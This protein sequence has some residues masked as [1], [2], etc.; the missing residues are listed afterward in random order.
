MEKIGSTFW[1][2]LFQIIA[3][4]S[5]KESPFDIAPV[6]ALGGGV[7]TFAKRSFDHIISVLQ[8]STKFVFTRDPYLRLLSGYVDKLFSPNPTF[9]K[10]IGTYAIRTHRKDPSV[11]SKKCGHDLTFA[12]FV[13]YFIHSE[14]NNSKRDGHFI[15]MYDHC[16][17]CQVKY[18]IIGKMES[19]EADT[20][21]ILDKLGL[22]ELHDR[23]S[24]DFRNQTNID[25]FKDQSNHV[26]GSGRTECLSNYDKQKRMWRKMQIRGTISKH[27]KFPFTK[28]KSN[29]VTSND[30]YQALLRAVGDA[31][32]PDIAQKYRME[33]VREAYS[34][35]SYNDMRK[36]QKIFKPDC[37]VFSYRCNINDYKPIKGKVLKP[38]YFD[39]STA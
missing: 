18:D 21:F 33:A 11:L 5:D 31:K 37:A 14:E 16:R 13:K 27:S 34:T 17:P 30:Y 24:V 2:R 35:V 6:A 25:S 9:W 29:S 26:I 7:K 32:D 22:K 4:A 15:P 28:K 8:T 38:F 20:L 3:G 1:R 10:S 39:I 19:F 36:L 23:L 12:E